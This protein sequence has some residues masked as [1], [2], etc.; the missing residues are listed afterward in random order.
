MKHLILDLALLTAVVL[1]NCLAA[2]RA[3]VIAIGPVRTVTAEHGV[4]PPGSSIVIL[5]K[6]AVRTGKASRG[7]VYLRR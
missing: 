2:D 3:D 5:T 6:D 1:G 4:I 7:T